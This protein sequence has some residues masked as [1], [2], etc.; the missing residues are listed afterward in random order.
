MRYKPNKVL[1]P[2]KPTDY[3]NVD[4]QWEI[5][6]NIISW[7]GGNGTSSAWRLVDGE[8]QYFMLPNVRVPVTGFSMNTD[9][10]SIG[11]NEMVY[12]D[13]AAGRF[14]IGDGIW[15]QSKYP[16]ETFVN[17]A[18]RYGSEIHIFMLLCLLAAL[19]APEETPVSYTH[20]DVYKRQV[21]MR[22]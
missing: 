15:D 20:L 19:N 14:G 8:L 7:D 6:P 5:D 16:P 2:I 18:E 22:F 9:V 11:M 4:F 17:T 13:V 3:Q 12:A 1:V 10:T 21:L